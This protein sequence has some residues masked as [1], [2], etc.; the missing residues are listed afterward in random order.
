MTAKRD[1]KRALYRAL[2]VA[3]VL[4][5]GFLMLSGMPYLSTAPSQGWVTVYKYC[6][7]FSNFLFM[8]LAASGAAMLVLLVFRSRAASAAAGV[9]FFTLIQVYVFVDVRVFLFH[10][11]HLNSLAIEA[12]L[13]P[14]Y[15][16]S[17]RFDSSDR[18]VALLG[19]GGVVAVQSLLLWLLAGVLFRGGRRAGLTRPLPVAGFFA[20]FLLAF[21]AE[22]TAFG[23][24]D[25]YSYV[26]VIR[27][28][29]VLPL[30]QPLTFKR[31]LETFLDRPAQETLPR[32]SLEYSSLDYPLPGFRYGRLP[33]PLNVVIIMVESMRFDMFAPETTPN[34][35]AFA[36]DALVL[37]DHYS[38]GNTSRFGGFALV[39][40]LYGTYWHPALASRQGP[41]L[42]KLLQE[43]GYDFK[44]Y[45]STDMDYPEFRQTLFVDVPEAIEDRMGPKKAKDRDRVLV[46]RFR[47]WL[48]NRSGARP[49]FC[50][51]FLDAPHAPYSFPEDSAHFTPFCR[52]V[53]YVKTDLRDQREEIFNRYR[54][55]VRCADGSL[56]EMLEALRA[57]NLLED[58]VVVVTGDHGEEFWETG[59]FGHNSAYTD[60]QTKVPMVIRIPG[61]APG[62]FSE[63]TNHFDIVPTLLG[64]LGDDNPPELY[65]NGKN[66]LADG[67]EDFMVL[68]GW[69]DCCL[70]TPHVKMRMALEAYNFFEGGVTDRSDRSL[71]DGAAVSAAKQSYLMAALKGIG[72]FLR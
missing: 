70:F 53:S 40:G 5:A 11:F 26:P 64:V 39:Y 42:V 59:Y 51:A 61:R 15:W 48:K 44:A 37:T 16:D 28:R 30:Y 10:H 34:L 4:N 1:K 43:N 65:S 72:R 50:F 23:L 41:V 20:V 35:C 69:D 22:K 2:F 54:N 68:A 56:G 9:L 12:M 66:L 17:V 33:R 14:G 36:S 29:K 47:E 25:F 62:V 32:V 63:P 6:A 27:Y 49:F 45:S 71:E 19:L 3:G 21:L 31:F 38:G 55:A 24:A 57:E 13:T 67:G 7:F 18:A 46:S 52:E 8:G 58:T 60:Y